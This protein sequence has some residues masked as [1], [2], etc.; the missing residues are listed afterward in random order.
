[1][2]REI[3]HLQVVTQRM[4]PDKIGYVRL[5]EFTEQADAGPG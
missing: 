3:I 5:S 1:M 2:R 4:E